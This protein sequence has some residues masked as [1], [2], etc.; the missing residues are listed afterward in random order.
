MKDFETGGVTF[1]EKASKPDVTPPSFP[2]RFGVTTALYLA[3]FLV[4]IKYG[5]G[6]DVVNVAGIIIPTV[7]FGLIF[8]RAVTK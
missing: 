4:P 3:L 5:F 2:F 8:S 7:L 1:K 6:L